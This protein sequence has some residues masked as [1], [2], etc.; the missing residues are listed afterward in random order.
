MAEAKKS[1]MSSDLT[2]FIGSE[3]LHFMP[4]FKQINYTDGV[5]FLVHHGC[6]WMVTDMLPVL[7]SHAM[8]RRE[9][10]VCITFKKNADKTAKITYDDGNANI[11]FIQ[12]YPFTDC[13][14]NEIKFFCTGKVLMLAREY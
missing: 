13:P 1:F 11:L 5:H 2:G 14:V 10:F 12:K 8:V 9:P 3:G 6:A 4:M 7:I